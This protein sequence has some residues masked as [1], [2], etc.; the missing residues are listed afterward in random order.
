MNPALKD[1]RQSLARCAAS[2][3]YLDTFYEVFL[4]QDESLRHMFGQV[5]MDQQKQ[6]LGA[7]LP[8][9]LELSFLD[10]ASPEIATAREE[11]RS[12]HRGQPAQHT[13]LWVDAVCATFRRH[14]PE[15]TDDLAARLRTQLQ[16]AT[17]LLQ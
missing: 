1:L 11:H 6:K 15:F 10:P 5:N 2:G 8:R 17:R 14:D 12:H 9:L 13:H 7:R 16:I 3:A 4:A